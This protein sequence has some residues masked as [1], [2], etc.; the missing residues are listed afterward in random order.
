MFATTARVLEIHDEVVA[1]DAVLVRTGPGAAAQ[2]ALTAV[3]IAVR[4][5]APSFLESIGLVQFSP[6]LEGLDLEECVRAAHHLAIPTHAQRLGKNGLMC[7]GVSWAFMEA[8]E[9]RSN[10]PLSVE[11]ERRVADAF[12]EVINGSEIVT[13]GALLEAWA[14][15]A[16]EEPVSL[17]EEL[18]RVLWL[19]PDAL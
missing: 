3:G 7:L 12:W 4:A 18:G 16:D 10:G 17:E 9:A 8:V 15:L 2:T 11:G 19:W 1:R 6:A 5:D 14:R 13:R